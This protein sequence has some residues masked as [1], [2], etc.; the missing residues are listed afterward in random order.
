M[1]IKNVNVTK[2]KTNSAT[3]AERPRDICFTLIRK[4]V[5]IASLS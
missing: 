1:A 2:S 5:K 3:M 4:I